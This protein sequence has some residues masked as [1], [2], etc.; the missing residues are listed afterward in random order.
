MIQLSI[1][2]G[3]TFRWTLRPETALQKY[4]PIT[5]ITM[6]ETGVR[7]TAAAHGMIEGWRCRVTRCKG[8]TRLNTVD[9]DHPRAA[10]YFQATVID[11]NTV[12]INTRNT[13]GDKAYMGGGILQ[14]GVPMD[15]TGC[16]VRAQIRPSVGSATV[17]LDLG[18]YIAV[19]VANFRI[20][21]DVPGSETSL[22]AGI[23]GVL[24]VEIEDSAPTPLVLSLPAIQVLFEQEIVR[25]E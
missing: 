16:V 25:G 23:G 14:Y 1:R 19:D 21:F 13:T 22:L 20:D 3:S 6:T 5:A 11:A 7:I 10:D 15:L 18:P 17:L 2:K 12:E 4:I 24:G 9:E 8:L